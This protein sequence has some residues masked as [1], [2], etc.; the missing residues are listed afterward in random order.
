M[1]R[2]AT[3]DRRSKEFSLCF[4]ANCAGFSR[5]KGKALFNDD[6]TNS[7]FLNETIQFTNGFNLEVECTREFTNLLTEY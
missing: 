5:E 2:Y 6:D 4:D 3:S 1:C 7:E